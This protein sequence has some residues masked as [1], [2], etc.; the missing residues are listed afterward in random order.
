DEFPVGTHIAWQYQDS[1]PELEGEITYWFP[2]VARVQI[3]D[4]SKTEGGSKAYHP[5]DVFVNA[6][7]D[8]S[9]SGGCVSLRPK[10]PVVKPDLTEENYPAGSILR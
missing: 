6:V 8:P 10:T 3:R 1:G 9:G 2:D 7:L 4:N 5:S